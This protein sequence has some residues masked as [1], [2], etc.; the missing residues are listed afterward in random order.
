MKMPK[1]YKSDY[2]VIA[3]AIF[4]LV[5]AVLSEGPIALVVS[6]AVVAGCYAI[7]FVGKLVIR[8]LYAAA[9]AGKFDKQ[10]EWVQKNGSDTLGMAI[11]FYFVGLIIWLGYK[12]VGTF[13]GWLKIGQWHFYEYQ[14]ACTSLDF[15]CNPSSEY[16]KIN[17]FLFWVYHFDVTIFLLITSAAAWWL[18]V[19]LVK[20]A[21]SN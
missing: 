3:I 21:D 12:I 18:I 7:Y 1:L 20:N 4:I 15:A 16:L 10:K 17:E 9:E 13:I 5:A 14:P 6:G 8:L 19:T 11:G 2:I